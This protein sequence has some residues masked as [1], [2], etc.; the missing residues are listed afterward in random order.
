[1]ITQSSRERADTRRS[2]GEAFQD[3]RVPLALIGVGIVWLLAGRTGVSER[4]EPG[5]RVQAARPRI[6]QTAVDLLMGSESEAQNGSSRSPIVEASGRSTT[7]TRDRGR[8]N[9]WVHQTAGAARGAARGAISSVR[10][11]GSAVL[12][13]AGRYTEHVGDAGGLVKRA[14]DPWLI[15][16]F[17]MVAG[18]AI[19]AL[20]PPTKLEQ[21]YVGE[22]RD[23]LRR[24]AAELA[25]EVA[26]CVREL[27]ESATRGSTHHTRKA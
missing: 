20:L 15:G 18:A 25:R 6:G 26:G 24:K 5:D 14:G 4:V 13:R 8:T 27:A 7:H 19:A 16:V 21:E 2:L 22:A 11:A 10:D 17:G 23:E 9:G 12:N 1:M 3:N